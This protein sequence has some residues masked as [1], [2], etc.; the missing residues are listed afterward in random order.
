MP[1]TLHDD[2]FG[3]LGYDPSLGE[4]YAEVALTP[5]H[6][7]EVAIGWTEEDNG[8]FPPVL[9]R[10]RAT[11]AKFR[12]KEP[13]HRSALAVAM[14]QRYRNSARPLDRVPK[15]EIFARGLIAERIAIAADG[16]AT[17]HYEDDAELF[18]DHCVMA[19]LDTYGSFD[20][21]SLQG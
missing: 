1:G 10:A 12:E 9:R 19:D 2:V 16:S 17:V 18:G 6:R 20:G 5:N 13:E 4:W 3:E 8:P 21:F 15:V 14:L 11:F 7:I